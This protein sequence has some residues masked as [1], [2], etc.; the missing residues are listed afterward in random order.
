[1]NVTTYGIDLAKNVFQI[2]GANARGKALVSKRLSRSK[3]LAYF[4]NCPRSLIGLEACGS[5]HYWARQLRALGHEVRQ[6]SPQYVKPYVKTNK[7][8]GNDAAAICEAVSRPEMRFVL[9]KNVEQQDVQSLHRVRQRLVHDRTALVNQTRGLLR[10]Y[11]VFI[12]VGIGAFRREIATVLE[13]AENELTALTREIIADQYER[14]HELDRRIVAYEARI[15]SIFRE[16]ECCQRM[17]QVEGVG[18][19]VATA[20]MAAVG[21]AQ[22]FK[23]GRHLAAWLGLVPRQHSSGQRTRLLGISKRGNTYVR[24]LLIHGARSVL[25]RSETKTDARSRWL[26]GVKARRG[27]NCASVALANKNARILWALLAHGD[28]YRKAA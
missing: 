8:D 23:N 25:Y 10:E 7:N 5:S 4:A 17:A 6:I 15:E 11:G 13:D 3:L 26:Q 9:V 21:D 12:P 20:L 16:N 14:L 22:E 24:T 2:H 18:P 1:M 19:M 28:A 27:V